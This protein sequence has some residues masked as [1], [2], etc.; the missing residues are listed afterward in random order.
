MA[1]FLFLLVLFL[2]SCL[3][4]G[5]R[6]PLHFFPIFSG[7]EEISIQ[8]P[9]NEYIL[10]FGEITEIKPILKGTVSSCSISE[11]LPMGLRLS[12]Q[13]VIY[14]AP[15]EVVNQKMYTITARHLLQNK[16]AAIQITVTQPISISYP[17]SPYTLG[18]GVSSTI[19]PNVIGS[20]QSCEI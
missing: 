17:S 6:K 12:A 2:A 1:K 7:N 20:I 10:N 3:E 8:Y 18:I 15:Q 16:I 11:A 19:S 5:E 4:M 14:G 13:C 9:Q